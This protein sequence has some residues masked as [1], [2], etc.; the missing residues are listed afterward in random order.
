MQKLY[1][2]PLLHFLILGIL[3]FYISSYGM[4]PINS[5]NK[6]IIIDKAIH[7]E[8]VNSFERQ[9]HKKPNKKELNNILENYIENEILY[10]EA[11]FIDLDKDE[12]LIKEI[13]IDKFKYI[14]NDSINMEN[15]SS[16]VLHKYYIKNLK[17]F[18]NDFYKKISFKHVYFNPKYHKNTLSQAKLFLE[19][20]RNNKDTKDSNIES[21]IFYAGSQFENYSENKL[22]TVFSHSFIKQL[23]DIPLHKWSEPIKSGFGTHIVFVKERIIRKK[24]FHELKNKIKNLYILDKNH[25]SYK[26]FYNKIR[27]KYTIIIQE[28]N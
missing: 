3:L 16:E 20:I 1:Q 7:S 9:H 28:K 22:N 21:D 25:F 10:R 24:T 15:L 6:T 19:S 4:K 12:P 2:E 26:N 5:D 23:W 14:S 13:L 8:L 11:L 18:K 27:T 17:E